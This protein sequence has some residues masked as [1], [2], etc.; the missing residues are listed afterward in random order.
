[1]V[2]TEL[3][4][5]VGTLTNIH[6]QKV[7]NELLEQKV[8]ERTREL[9]EANRE[10]AISNSELQ[11]F[12]SVASHDLKE[13]LRKILFF[14]SLISDKAPLT[15][16]TSTYL[17]KILR[18]SRRMSNLIDDLLSFA[19]L[20]GPNLFQPTDPGE[21]VRDILLDLEL[22]IEEKKAVIDIGP[23]P[24]VEAIP[25]LLR[26][27][28]QN[29]ISNALKFTKPGTAPHVSISAALVNTVSAEAAPDANGAY[30]RIT[31]ADNGIGF[32]EKYAEK[33]FTIFQRLNTRTEYEG[34]GIGLAIAKKIID[35]HNGAITARSTPGE[36]SVFH[37]FLP[38]RQT[39]MHKTKEENQFA[40]TGL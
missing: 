26:Q 25:A 13:P 3:T 12:T 23:I 40:A 4:R 38:V 6:E 37:L 5:W 34:T 2:G 35:R 14:G 24:Q 1:M 31:I 17:E 10:L 28:F 39:E 33:I 36:G 8:A 7:L 20:S 27:L 19:S 18:A 29:I 22:S 11:Q 30:C 9:L 15:E 16:E 21:I 32:E